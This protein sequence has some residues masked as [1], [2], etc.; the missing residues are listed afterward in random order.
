MDTSDG[1]V[2]ETKKKRKKKVAPPYKKKTTTS[3]DGGQI[4]DNVNGNVD[5]IH[6]QENVENNGEPLN[7]LVE[8]NDENFDNEGES[9]ESAYDI[10][11][12]RMVVSSCDEEDTIYPEFNH[13]TTLQ[14]W[15]IPNFSL[16]CCLQME[17]FLEQI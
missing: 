9:S 7:G 11:E 2:E 8:D 5:T 14:I 4:Y 10:N 13:F 3:K 17:E 1:E 15:L 16:A 6:V 12:E